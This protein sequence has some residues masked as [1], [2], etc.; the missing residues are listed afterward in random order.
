VQ[1]IAPVQ[2]G[3]KSTNVTIC[4]GCNI[5][6]NIGPLAP[7]AKGLFYVLILNT[8]RIEGE[9]RIVIFL[10]KY[11]KPPHFFPNF[12]LPSLHF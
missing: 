12:Y 2:Q 8:P 7:I 4:K 9:I 5:G 6:A 10:E 3:L 1:V 11:Y